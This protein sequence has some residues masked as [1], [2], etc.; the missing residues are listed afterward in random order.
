MLCHVVPTYQVSSTFNITVFIFQQFLQSFSTG[1]NAPVPDAAWSFVQH[2]LVEMA[3]ACLQTSKENRIT[4]SYFYKI[5]SNLQQLVSEVS[6]LRNDFLCY[7]SLLVP[8]KM[9]IFAVEE[10]GWDLKVDSFACHG[11]IFGSANCKILRG[12]FCL[13]P[14]DQP[15][16]PAGIPPA[17]SY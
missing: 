12:G 15:T 17:K 16:I 7:D 3:R 14:T 9:G 11:F 2:Q 13:L 5:S 1:A 4:A 10:P 6:I 8:R